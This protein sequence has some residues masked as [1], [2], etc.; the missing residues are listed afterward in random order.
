MIWNQGVRKGKTG[1]DGDGK[2]VRTGKLTGEGE[3]F[4][5]F[6]FGIYMSN[7]L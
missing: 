4:L 1:R 7:C 5:V 3:N 2:R 6:K